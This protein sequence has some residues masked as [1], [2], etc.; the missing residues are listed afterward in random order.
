MSKEQEIMNY[1]NEKIFEPALEY[2]KANKKLNIVKG[3]NLTKIRMSKLP[4]RKM[5]NY[6]WSAIVGTE[7]SINFSDILVRN[8][9]TRFEDVLEEVRVKFNNDYLKGV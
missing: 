4:A 3:V 8:G 6:F 1:F 2:G 7:H 5:I 9:L